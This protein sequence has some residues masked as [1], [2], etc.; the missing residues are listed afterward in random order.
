MEQADIQTKF[1][2]KWTGNN[3]LLS[4]SAQLVVLLFLFGNWKFAITLLAYYHIFQLMKLLLR[5]ALADYVHFHY[6]NIKLSFS[7]WNLLYL[8]LKNVTFWII[9]FD[10]PYVGVKVPLAKLYR[11][12]PS[13]RLPETH[14][15]Q[16]MGIERWDQ[17]YRLLI[18]CCSELKICLDLSNKKWLRIDTDSLRVYLPYEKSNIA[19]EQKKIYPNG[20]PNF[21]EPS[22]KLYSILNIPL[23]VAARFFWSVIDINLRNTEV[24]NILNP[25]YITPIDQDKDL[26]HESKSSSIVDPI[27][28]A[29]RVT[30]NG[31]KPKMKKIT[32]KMHLTAVIGEISIYFKSSTKLRKIFRDISVYEGKNFVLK[33]ADS[34]CVSLNSCILDLQIVEFEKNVSESKS[35]MET[36]IPLAEEKAIIGRVLTLKVDASI[37]PPYNV[38][39]DYVDDVIEATNSQ[40][41]WKYAQDIQASN[42]LATLS[43]WVGLC[44]ED[45]GLEMFARSIASNIISAAARNSNAISWTD[46]MKLIW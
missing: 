43:P 38:D 21:V 31:I 16:R 25:G 6:E 19:E 26:I 45:S 32:D 46:E 8:E 35:L 20:Y 24:H 36:C 44:W 29:L 41:K 34:T 39:A 23:G 30:T 27:R 28:K 40:F 12:L 4:V 17:S 42:I 13:L 7:K 11:P 2:I 3:N 14:F 22:Y 9:W 5:K 1:P 18:F 37:N 33:K 15:Q 10:I